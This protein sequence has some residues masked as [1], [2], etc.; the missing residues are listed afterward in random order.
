M[1]PKEKAKELIEKFKPHV[2]CFMGSGMLSN[3]YDENVALNEAKKCALICAQTV[4]E[5]TPMNPS[6]NE[7]EDGINMHSEDFWE[8][9]IDW[10]KGNMEEIFDEA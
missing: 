5:S 2:Y 9:V 4:L 1:R 10:L 7:K 6:M 3:S 8:D